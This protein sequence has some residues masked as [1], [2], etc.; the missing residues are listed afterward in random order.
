MWPLYSLLIL[1]NRLLCISE[2]WYT[3][4]QIWLP[5]KLYVLHKLSYCLSLPVSCSL[6]SPVPASQMVRFTPVSSSASLHRPVSEE[7]SEPF[8]QHWCPPDRQVESAGAHRIDWLWRWQQG[9]EWQLS[10]QSGMAKGELGKVIRI[11]PTNLEGWKNARQK[12]SK[13]YLNMVIKYDY[14]LYAAGIKSN[15]VSKE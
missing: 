11:H 10:D 12:K 8:P 3:D 13:K 2:S 5:N 4:V 9:Q 15:K 7:H 1:M 14:T 6:C